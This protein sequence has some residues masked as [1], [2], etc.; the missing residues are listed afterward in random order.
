MGCVFLLDNKLIINLEK[1]SGGLFFC[2]GAG[3]SSYVIRGVDQCYVVWILLAPVWHDVCLS[4]IWAFLGMNLGIFHFSSNYF[5]VLSFY[6]SVPFGV[7]G[8]FMAGYIEI[9]SFSED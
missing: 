5:G 6:H 7:F 1:S 2:Q 4:W 3:L 9:S 8:G